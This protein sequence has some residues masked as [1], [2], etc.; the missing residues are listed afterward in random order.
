M[1]LLQPGYY[2]VG[3]TK[4]LNN[5]AKHPEYSNMSFSA[6]LVPFR[7]NPYLIRERGI[8]NWNIL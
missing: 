6:K 1:N 7:V 2:L 3:N 5:V 4:A 8:Q